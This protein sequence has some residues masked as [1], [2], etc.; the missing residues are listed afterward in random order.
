MA[1]QK[2]LNFVTITSSMRPGRMSDRVLAVALKA[3]KEQG[4]D[5]TVM[6]M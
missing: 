4:H 6:G 1:T 5:Y 2:A 3:I